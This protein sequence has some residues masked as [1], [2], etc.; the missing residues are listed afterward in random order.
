M[1][2]AANYAVANDA[3][4][5]PIAGAD[6]TSEMTACIGRAPPT[7]ESRTPLSPTRR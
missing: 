3:I 7:A 6:N 4:T 1:V 2:S 5:V